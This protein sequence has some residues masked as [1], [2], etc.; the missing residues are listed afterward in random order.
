MLWR[1]TNL[2]LLN[3]KD[4]LKCLV[5]GNIKDID[6]EMRITDR[7]EKQ[8]LSE[9]YIGLAIK[10]LHIGKITR[11]R[12]AEY[13]DIA[14]SEVPSFLKKYGYSENEDYTIAFSAT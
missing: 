5:E 14:F 9:R 13:V 10:A 12:F 3:R 6:K 8:Y 11:A 7:G 2:N 1:L 4:V